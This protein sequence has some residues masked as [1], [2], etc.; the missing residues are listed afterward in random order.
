MQEPCTNRIVLTFNDLR[1]SKESSGSQTVLLK[2]LV[3][4]VAYEEIFC[5]L[6]F[7]E[8]SSGGGC[9]DTIFL[10]ICRI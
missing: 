9:F 1:I 2:A 3:E 8:H 6:A 10:I 4:L 5:Y 7:C